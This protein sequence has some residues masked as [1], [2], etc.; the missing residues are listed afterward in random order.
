MPD[1]LTMSGGQVTSHGSVAER[2]L[3]ANMSTAGLRTN[4]TLSY[5]QWKDVDTRVIREMERRLRGVSDL[6]GAG[7]TRNLNNLGFTVDQW[8]TMSDPGTAN[9]SMDGLT[10]GQS[11]RPDFVTNIVPLP[12]THSDWDI[13][14]R[15]LQAS[16]MPGGPPLD[17]VMAESA[18]R[19]VAEQ[20]EDMLFNGYSALSFGGGTIYG[21]TTHP[22]RNG[23]TS[24]T[25]GAWSTFGTTAT[26]DSIRTDVLA[27]IAVLNADRFY[28]PFVMYI[29]TALESI[30]D[31]DYR[32]AG[33]NRTIRERLLAIQSISDIRST[34]QLAADNI[35]IVS[36]TSD[37]IDLV[38]GLNTTNV[39]WDSH[40]GFQLHFKVM[41]VIVPR[42]KAD[43]SGRSGIY[44]LRPA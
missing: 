22:S 39:E 24:F 32:A 18:G 23:T 43:Y 31:N 21:Y 5:D 4:A 28:G 9:V 19:R 34:D 42:V 25:S 2:L 33:D 20:N 10:R 26:G 35:V 17:T 29:P 41:N 30:L 40:G 1:I 36:L 12:I 14:A 8:P 3:R 16:R 44:H 27:A 6:F 37:V 7:L 15:E 13:N 11:D 38:V